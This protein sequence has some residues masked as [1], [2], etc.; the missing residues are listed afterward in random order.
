MGT[1]TIRRIPDEVIEGV[2]TSAELHH[3]SMEQEVRELLQHRYGPR[4][5]VLRRIR[6]RWED[7]PQTGANEVEQWREKGR[8]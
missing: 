6:A 8:R 1:L 3:R 7:L 5:Q 2:R 4:S